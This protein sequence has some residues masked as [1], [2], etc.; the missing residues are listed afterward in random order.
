M[1]PPW[2]KAGSRVKSREKAFFASKTL[3]RRHQGHHSKRL[4]QRMKVV[5]LFIGVSCDPVRPLRPACSSQPPRSRKPKPVCSSSPTK[6]TAMAL[7]SALRTARHAARLPRCPIVYRGILYRPP[8]SAGSTPTKLPT[9]CRKLPES[10]RSMGAMHTLPSPA[11]A[12]MRDFR[13]P[14]AISGPRKRRDVAERSGYGKRL[15]L[16]GCELLLT[17]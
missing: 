11:S 2:A 17:A 12:E 8:P 1:G 5:L 16:E 14:S 7:T 3:S 15:R 9:R 13:V 4:V 6:T 10:A